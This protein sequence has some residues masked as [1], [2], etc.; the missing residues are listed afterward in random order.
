MFDIVFDAV[1]SS[2]HQ[3]H[4]TRNQTQTPKQQESTLSYFRNLFG[5]YFPQ[6]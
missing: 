4:N 6:N 3:L 1:S 5:P 2:F